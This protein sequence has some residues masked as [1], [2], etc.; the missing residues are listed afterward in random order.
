MIVAIDGPV[1]SGKSAVGRRVADAL[2]LT[3]VDSGLMYR[4]VGRLA[5]E[6][7]L[8]L[9][10]ADA[11]TRLAGATTVHIDGPCVHV[12]GR[13]VTGHV[14]APDLSA[15]ASQV[16]QAPG[17][18]LAV[19]AQLRAMGRG[20][21]VMAGRDIGT[22]VFPDADHKFYLTASSEVRARRRAAQI[23]QRGEHADPERLRVEVEERDRRDA[24]RAVA[25]MRPAEDA[26]ILDTED[27]GLA[28]V[29]AEVLR[30]VRGAA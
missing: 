19:V 28:E 13:D 3:F 30:G 21:V 11:L 14:Y 27:L 23:A 16:A 24:S 25:P 22:V 9:G 6:R 7:G 4:V 10:D 20:G 29:V 12:D 18:R 8:D 2:G 17:V 15:A 5:V 26:V 1:G